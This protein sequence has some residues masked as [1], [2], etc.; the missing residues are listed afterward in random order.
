MSNC[1]K[2]LQQSR[3]KLIVLSLVLIFFS[4]K[5]YIILNNEDL[6]IRIRNITEAHGGVIRGHF[7]LQKQQNF[8]RNFLGYSSTVNLD[9]FSQNITNIS[10]QIL[11]QSLPEAKQLLLLPF[12]NQY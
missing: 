6:R 11:W 4:L 3:W 9:L 5:T 1:E 10:Q 12:R 7:C 2:Y 8:Y